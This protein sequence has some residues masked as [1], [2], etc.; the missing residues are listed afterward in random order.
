M[1]I[2]NYTTDIDIDQIL[3]NTLED[4][5]L[6]NKDELSGKSLEKYTAFVNRFGNKK[7]NIINTSELEVT[8]FTGSNVEDDT[9]I[10]DFNTLPSEDVTI[11]INFLTLLS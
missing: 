10:I 4:N 9:E 5:V 2:E 3:V 6:I 7:Y 1:L 8:R 11:I